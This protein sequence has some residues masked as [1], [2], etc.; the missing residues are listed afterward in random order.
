M[1]KK[2][3]AGMSVALAL[4][5]SVSMGA[6]AA[7]GDDE[8]TPE[9]PQHFAYTAADCYSAGNYEYWKKGNKYYEDEACTMEITQEETVIP[10]RQHD[11]GADADYD[12]DYNGYHWKVCAYSDCDGTD[13]PEEHVFEDGECVCGALE[14]EQLE[15]DTYTI[16]IETAQNG[17]VTADKEEA[18]EGETVTLTV[19]PASG[20]ELD[21]L[22]Y[23]D[24]EQDYPITDYTFTMPAADVTVAAAFKAIDYTI[25]VNSA[26]NGAVTVNEGKETAIIGEQVT[27][28]ITPDT[29]YDLD[30]IAYNDGTEHDITG[31]VVYGEIITVT[32]TMPA[33]DV[34]V[35]ATFKTEQE[36]SVTISDG[37][38]HGTVSANP[39]S[40][41]AG[42]AITVTVNPATGYV[43]ESLMYNETPITERI[44]E[45]Y[46]FNMPADDVVITATFTLK[47]Y[48]VL[49]ENGADANGT[50]VADKS[51]AKAGEKVTL[52][53]TPAEGYHLNSIACEDE[54]DTEI[55]KEE[56]GTYT[57]T[58]PANSVQ[59]IAVFEAHDYNSG[60][61]DGEC[62]CGE[63]N[64]F[65]GYELWQFTE[66]ET[67][68]GASRTD[69]ANSVIISAT[70]SDQEAWHIKFTTMIDN[71]RL[72]GYYEVTYNIK[73]E[74]TT[75]LIKFESDDG[76]Y[77]QN[78]YN[79]VAG[80]NIVT[81]KF[82][83][84]KVSE[85][86]Q[87]N[88]V[89]QLGALPK[90]FEVEITGVTIRQTTGNYMDGWWAD[91]DSAA[92]AAKT[93]N[94]DGTF[95]INAT[96]INE[97]WRL[98]LAKDVVLEAGHEYELTFA[99]VLTG[100]SRTENLVYEIYKRDKVNDQE[101]SDNEGKV[102]VA[103]VTDGYCWA[104]RDGVYVKTFKFT[105]KENITI[106]SC[107][108]Y[109][110]ITDADH[111]I[112]LTVGYI[113]WVDVTPAAED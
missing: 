36:Y 93:D 40:A 80:D 35:T 11:F 76:I 28:T 73:S 42:T 92:Q 87:A 37:I 50:V 30:T 82:V 10:K 41:K 23:N 64:G 61:R 15:P 34:S 67:N 39:T 91:T 109:G 33:H 100:R 90:E 19:T 12:R 110:A 43:L 60:E 3:F 52:T 94:A 49:V 102:A 13:E 63:A 103:D 111:P 71:A 107:L 8:G 17:T 89:L 96:G 26:D 5:M 48:D 9:T 83:V 84:G 47:S 22:V 78:E 53:V 45:N 57:F 86:G 51:T 105:A 68:L 79:L 16:T 2:R 101:E 25:T 4:A 21:T 88:A 29:G 62:S 106:G 14:N 20:Y 66:D 112:V 95:T 65:E 113:N 31:D 69:T 99:F 1:N 97:S 18:E 98:K 54:S 7:C 104:D 56:D 24:G 74:S 72:G 27:L 75:G 108:Q 32:F 58:M 46:T 38:E 59:I 55:T 6:L 81:F 70:N 44:G 77:I 85:F